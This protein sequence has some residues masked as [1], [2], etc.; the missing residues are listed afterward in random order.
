MLR[1]NSDLH[2]VVVG[3]QK[4]RQVSAT[5]EHSIED[6]FTVRV[7]QPDREA[8]EDSPRDGC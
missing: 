8:N 3:V 6:E 4:R 5:V 7:F 2:K 1:V